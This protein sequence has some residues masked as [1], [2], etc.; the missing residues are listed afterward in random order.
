LYLEYCFPPVA[1]FDT[2]LSD[3]TNINFF[4]PSIVAQNTSETENKKKE[5]EQKHQTEQEKK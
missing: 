2:D 5:E 3:C 4:T 1:F